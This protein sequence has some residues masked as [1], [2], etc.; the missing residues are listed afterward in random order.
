M[1]KSVNLIH[2]GIGL[3]GGSA[4]QMIR[5]LRDNWRSQLG[6]D[7]LH[8]AF[9]DTSGGVVCDEP[10]GYSEATIEAILSART[11]G[12]KL[13]TAAPSLGLT[14]RTVDDALAIAFEMGPTIVIDCAASDRTADLSARAIAG[15]HGAV[16]SNKA[17]LALPWDDKRSKLL[18]GETHFGGRVRYEATC[19]AGLP[20]IATLRSLLDS[21]DSIVEISGALSGTFGAIFADLAVGVPFSAAVRSA[22][23]KGYTEPDPRD[24]L[25][26]LDV[27]R[28]TL[29]LA[30][31]IGL[32]IDLDSIAVETLV[33][34]HLAG[35]S[36]DEFLD[37]LERE[38]SVMAD[39]VDQARSRGSTLKYLARVSASEGV[40]VGLSETPA[41][42]I[43][44][45]LQ[46]PEN[47]L[48]FR[49]ERYDAYPLTVIGPGAGAS[50]TAAGVVAN[51]L[52]LVREFGE[53]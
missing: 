45:S 47:I 24:D 10:A 42:T 26:G 16:F 22:R 1:S 19:G 32:P 36:V 33:P 23:N 51:L 35:V 52:S 13:T 5:S 37:G 6:V 43:L 40:S 38:D 34:A 50:V 28:K 9:V 31:T 20:V 29:I 12:D 25:S 39:R 3:I 44:G 8:R 27:A 30:R 17:P 46:G 11:G 53:D 7:V 14:P 48:T 4:I 49:S 18:W 21:G 41:N 15:G 2:V